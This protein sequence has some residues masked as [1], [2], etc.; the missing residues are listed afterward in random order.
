MKLIGS[1]RSAAQTLGLNEVNMKV[2]LLPLVLLLSSLSIAA[3]KLPEWYRVYTFDESVIDM[4]TSK[5]IMG[6]DIGRITFRWTFDQPEVPS[7]NPKKIYQSRLETIEFK[8][9]D[10]RYRYYEVKLLDPGGKVI[11]SELMS[12]PYKWHEIEPG[13]VIATIS[14][15]ACELIAGK[16]DPSP[17]KLKREEQSESDRVVQF[18]LSIKNTLERSRDFRPVIEKFFAAD[19]L[20]GYLGD[21]DANWFYNLNRD[22]ALSASHAELQEF[23]VASLNAGYLTALYLIS[24]MPSDDAAVPSEPVPEEKMIPADVYQLI[25]SH[26]YTVT[27]KANERGY[28]YLAEKIDSVERMRSYTDLLERIAALM[29]K[30]VT[31]VQA[32]RS[33]EY[34]NMLEDSQIES[35]LCSGECLGLPK[36]TKLIQINLPLVHLQLAEIRGELKVVSAK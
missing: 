29:R 3:Q 4:N 1:P 35:A 20:K 12:S 2:L 22:T 21:E 7:G 16:I 11:S 34:R 26:A 24:Q 8:C 28:D 9:S 19:F 14:I 13:S 17:I 10:Q 27:Y 25:N 5:P 31:R 36:G 15:P 6:G 18:A 33:Q 30:H 32:E 23:Y